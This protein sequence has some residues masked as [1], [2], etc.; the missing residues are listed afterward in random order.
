MKTLF[1]LTFFI[2]A[3]ALAQ[4]ILVQAPSSSKIDYEHFLAQH[5][6]TR[7]MVHFEQ[8]I[9]QINPSQESQLFSLSDSFND[10][11]DFVISSLKEIQKEAPLTLSSLRF[12]RD[13]S[14]KA[15]AKDLSAQ[16]KK[17]L[18]HAYCK[19]VTLLNEGPSR[20][21]CREEYVSLEKLAK[22]FP[23]HDTLLIESMSFSLNEKSMATL[24]P[25]TA[26]QWTL[27]S[28]SQTTIRFYGTYG[29]LLNQHFV[30]ENWVEGN[31][32]NF[33]HRIEDMNAL[34]RGTVFFNESCA[35]RLLKDESKKSWVME[36]K[37]WLYVAGAVV[38]GGI[39]YSLKDK[40]IVV[41]T[42]LK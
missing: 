33:T 9:A 30:T 2:P 34:H 16:D 32:E 7:S 18:L 31:C 37:T 29:Q 5:P 13:L 36:K 10:R 28:N 23:H 39:V 21:V 14:E 35:P 38:L 40:D 24:S 27:V 1:L 12:V 25:Q 42:S 8:K 19:S 17:E 26:Y 15:L 6:E 11:L 22:K 3:I 41:N 20:F 4:N